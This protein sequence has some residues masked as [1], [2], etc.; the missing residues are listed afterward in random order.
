ME[1][2]NWLSTQTVLGSTALEWSFGALAFF[3]TWVLLTTTVNFLVSKLRL[4]AQKTEATADDFAVDLLDNIH[5]LTYFA[6]ALTA[7]SFWV[8]L[9]APIQSVFYKL[10]V[11]AVC[12][13]IGLW[14]G[15]IVSYLVRRYIY[16]QS[17][18]QHAAVLKTMRGPF[19]FIGV[20]LIW[21]L[22]LLTILQNFGVDVSTLVAGL[23]IG[24]IAIAL[25]VQTVLGDLFAAF[26]I[27]IDKPF[28][29]GDFIVSG[30]IVGNVA[31]IGL[32]TTHINSLSGERMVVSN[33]DLLSS[34]IRNFTHLEERRIVFSFGVLYQTP[35]ESAKMISG[36]VKTIIDD[37]DGIH[38]DRCHFKSFGDSSLDYEVVYFVQDPDF[39]IYMTMQEKI[40]LALM[41]KFESEGIEFAYPTRTLFL[42]QEEPLRATLEN[43][44]DEQQPEN[45]GETA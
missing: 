38:F 25:A 31:H 35:V 32:K 44:I 28:V 24:G 12:L 37:I 18:D 7:L 9:P 2:F 1:I 23:G 11:L 36:W 16:N 27:V 20:F 4:L 26:A 19:E 40:N 45:S 21:A 17:D 43:H 8:V 22:V 15:A 42:T 3:I 39:N 34:R 10:P 41:E 14:S 5:G 13:Q 30:D 33:S 29:V 6:I